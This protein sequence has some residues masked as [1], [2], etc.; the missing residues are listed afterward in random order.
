MKAR[1]F[2]LFLLFL[3]FGAGAQVVEND[4]I[5]NDS[6]VFNTEMEELVIGGSTMSADDKKQLLLLRRRVLKV[7]PYAKLAAEKLTMLAGNM[8]KLKTEKEKKKYAKIVEKYLE[9]EFEG[10]LKKLTRKEGQILVKLIYRQTGHTTFD[11]IKEHKSGWKA[12][13]SSRMAKLFDINLKAKYSPAT[14]TEDYAIEGYLI[15]AFEERRLV[16]QDPAFAI[17]YDAITEN[18]REKNK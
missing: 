17:D 4:S 8:D 1:I 10:Q 16:K 3:T 9:N 11:L 12:F 13:W 15:K 5:E 18:W 6:I 7:Y 2:L 14:V